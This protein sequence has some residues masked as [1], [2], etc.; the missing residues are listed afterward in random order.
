[1]VNWKSLYDIAERILTEMYANVAYCW[2]MAKLPNRTC[3]FVPQSARYQ[4]TQPLLSMHWIHYSTVF[5]LPTS[6]AENLWLKWKIKNDSSS[7]HP[8]IYHSTKNLDFSTLFVAGKW[9]RNLVLISVTKVPLRLTI[10]IGESLSHHN[11][12]NRLSKF[13][14]IWQSLFLKC[15]VEKSRLSYQLIIRNFLRGIFHRKFWPIRYSFF[16]LY[17]ITS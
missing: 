16:Y 6:V 5:C 1:M 8:T 7:S 9:R 2:C 17:S 15:F 10:Q 12:T 14:I 11:S 13:Y 3:N 4:A